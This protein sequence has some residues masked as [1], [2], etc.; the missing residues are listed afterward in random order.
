MA[1][2]NIFEIIAENNDLAR[3]VERIDRLFRKEKTITTHIY[4]GIYSI[5][6]YV[7]VYCFKEWKGRGKCIDVKDFLNTVGYSN[8]MER[9]HDNLDD[10]LTFI[11]IVL[12]FYQVANEKIFKHDRTTE[13]DNDKFRI[14]WDKMM[15][16]LSQYN[17]TFVYDK[18]QE[19]S[20]IV[21]DKVEVTAVAEIVEPPLAMQIIKYNH[22]AL[23]E[24][25]DEKKAI[26]L[27]MGSD[28]EP[29][30]KS[31]SAVN[32]SLSDDIF[33]ILNNM[34]LR[35]NNCDKADKN[36]KEFVAQMDENELLK[37]YDEL[38]QMML[39]AYLELNQQERKKEF[40]ELKNK[41]EQ[42]GTN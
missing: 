34:N 3:E 12:N 20:I 30:R 29:K 6:E 8:I 23:K 21:E 40:S 42:E 1:R 19:R 11:E 24:N 18:E 35:H 7:G 37:W 9:A 39:L 38:Y 41:I 33:Y 26:L 31:L 10:F 25:I 36:Y 32:R 2:K 22:Y 17:Y 27:R 16:N 4:Y 14:L 15:D 28:L 5:E 13:T